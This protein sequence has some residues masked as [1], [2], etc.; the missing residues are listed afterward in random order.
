MRNE[1]A[2]R[3]LVIDV[4]SDGIKQ[5]GRNGATREV[6]GTTIKLDVADDVLPMITG[7]KMY[8]KG[9]VG[10]ALALMQAPCNHVSDFESRGCNYWKLWADED[11]NLELDYP[12][13]K[14]LEGIIKDINRDPHSR[15]H[16]IDLWNQQNLSHLSLPCCHYGYQF[17]IQGNNINMIWTQRSADLMIGVPSDMIL[18]TIYLRIVADATGYEANEIT[19]NFGSTHIYEEHVENA[20]EY[21][22][23]KMLKLPTLQIDKKNFTELTQDNFRVKGYYHKPAIKFELKS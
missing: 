8:Y 9:I 21:V 22:G 2:Y 7:R 15:R 20:F 6:F 12:I 10:E 4:L 16:I 14:Q 17:N 18:A 23:R 11:G 13:R 3:Q 19:M 5:E 1:R